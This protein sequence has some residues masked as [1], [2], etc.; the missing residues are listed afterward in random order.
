MPAIRRSLALEQGAVYRDE[1][2]LKQPGGAPIDLTG[3]TARMQI[4]TLDDR[5]LLDLSTSPGRGLVIDGPA[6]VIYRYITA[7]QTAQLPVDGGEYDLKITPPSGPDD[8]WRLYKGPVSVSAG[9]T[10]DD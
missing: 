6:G 9:V 2:R 1:I 4:R 10:R 8:T 5:L 3:C 7:G